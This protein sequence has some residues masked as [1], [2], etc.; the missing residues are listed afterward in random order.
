[1]LLLALVLW[2]E[3]ETYGGTSR[4]VTVHV[5]SASVN[6]QLLLLPIMPMCT[7]CCCCCCCC[8]CDVAD[9][10]SCA[11]AGETVELFYNPDLTPLRGRPFIDVQGAFNR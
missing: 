5:V 1:M 9:F 4:P 7:G 3:R 10:S 11:Q 8:C 6:E 2:L